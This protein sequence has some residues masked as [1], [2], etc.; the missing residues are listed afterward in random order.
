MPETNNEDCAKTVESIAT[1]VRVKFNILKAFGIQSKIENK[2]RKIIAEV[3][4]NQGKRLMMEN[5]IK[6]KLTGKVVNTN[7]S[8]GKIYINDSLTQLNRNLFF[9][10]R[11]LTRK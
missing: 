9:K 6:S 10:A 4:T 1:P 7:W 11:T 2:S 3:Q 8:H 5:V